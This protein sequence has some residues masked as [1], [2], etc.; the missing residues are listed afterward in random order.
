MY[1]I[2]VMGEKESICI[3]SALGMTAFYTDTKKEAQ[4]TLNKLLKA[5]FAIIY[6][7]EKTAEMINEEIEKLKF[8]PQPAII[9]IPGMN[10]NTGA[11][12]EQMSKSVEKAVGSNILK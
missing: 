12:M 6:I 9:L 10:G 1:K 3:F 4:D 8:N 11:G 5:D 7:T 2:A